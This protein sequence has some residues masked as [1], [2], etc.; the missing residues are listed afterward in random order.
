MCLLFAE[1]RSKYSRYIL[2]YYPGTPENDQLVEALCQS[3]K[4]PRSKGYY[5]FDILFA[6]WKNII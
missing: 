4:R 5:L 3:M 2:G 1:P 6:V